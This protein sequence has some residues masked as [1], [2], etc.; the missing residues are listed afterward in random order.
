[1]GDACVY[2]DGEKAK[3]EWGGLG[4]GRKKRGRELRLVAVTRVMK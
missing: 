3:C 2:D 4:S 1:M